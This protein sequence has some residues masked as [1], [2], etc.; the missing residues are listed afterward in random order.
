MSIFRSI[1][2]IVLALALLG[3]CATTKTFN[4][5]SNTDP[6]GV[7]ETVE[8]KTTGRVTLGSKQK[9]S[10]GEFSYEWDGWD[11]IG[12]GKVS[13]GGRGVDQQSESATD[14][15]NGVVATVKLVG[16]L[17]N[18]L[19]ETEAQKQDVLPTEDAEV[20]ILRILNGE[21]TPEDV[22]RQILDRIDKNGETK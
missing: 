12:G 8:F 18:A 11:G 21:D 2:A 4:S 9:L 14:L 1:T 20:A 3:G 19:S 6:D 17:M 22:L 16:Q 13:A 15:I 7:T 5:I 10:E